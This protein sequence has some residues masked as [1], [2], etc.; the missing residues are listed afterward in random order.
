MRPA[1]AAPRPHSRCLPQPPPPPGKAERGTSPG[2]GRRLTPPAPRSGR[3]SPMSFSLT[4]RG[5]LAIYGAALPTGSGTCN[6]ERTPAARRRRR[7]WDKMAAAARGVARGGEAAAWPRPAARGWAAGG[8][9]PPSLLPRADGASGR[10]GGGRPRE[11]VFSPCP[12]S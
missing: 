10:G 8:R 3:P 9:R 2:H 7:D 5:K 11:P 12:S 4:L 6:G 1:P